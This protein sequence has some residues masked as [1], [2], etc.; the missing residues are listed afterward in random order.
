MFQFL[1]ELCMPGKTPFILERK[2]PQERKQSFRVFL[3]FLSVYRGTECT[4]ISSVA[5]HFLLPCAHRYEI[6]CYF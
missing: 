2:L 3:G 5:V 6:F 4:Q 1:T